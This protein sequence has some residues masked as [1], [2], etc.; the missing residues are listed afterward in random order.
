MLWP[1]TFGFSLRDALG[2]YNGASS[3]KMTEYNNICTSGGALWTGYSHPE[4]DVVTNQNEVNNNL[5]LAKSNHTSVRNVRGPMNGCY[6][7]LR[8]PIAPSTATP[9]DT[10]TFKV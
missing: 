5:I 7:L 1:K 10:S 9:K 4:V 3:E 6:N 8:K 2:V